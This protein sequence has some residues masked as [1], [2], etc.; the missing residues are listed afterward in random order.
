LS[1]EVV[2]LAS[3]KT[4]QGQEVRIGTSSSVMVDNARV[5]TTD[6]A[7]TNGVIHVIDTV[8]LPS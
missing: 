7:A 2:K 4:L 1:S 6:V 5:L 3:A 8:L